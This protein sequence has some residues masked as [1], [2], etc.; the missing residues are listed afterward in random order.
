[1]IKTGSA[2]VRGVR[3][4]AFNLAIAIRGIDLTGA[5]LGAVV[6]Q[7]WDNDPADPEIEPVVTLD[8]VGTYEG[9]PVSNLTVAIAK[10]A[11]E[12]I[13]A[14]SEVGDDLEWVWYLTVQTGGADTEYRLLEGKFVVGGAAGGPGSGGTLTATVLDQAVTVEIE[15][16]AALGPLV[17]AATEAA[18]NAQAS[19]DAVVAIAGDLLAFPSGHDADL[20]RIREPFLF[21]PGVDLS[22]FYYISQFDNNVPGA[23][24]RFYLAVSRDDDGEG[25]NATLVSLLSEAEP[26]SGN[27][28]FVTDPQGDSGVYLGGWVAA[29]SADV[30]NATNGTY[31]TAGLL[32]KPVLD[33]VGWKQAVRD[34]VATGAP[35]TA[36]VRS[37]GT[38]LFTGMTEYDFDNNS[39]DNGGTFRTVFTLPAPVLR[40]RAIFALSDADAVNVARAAIA[41]VATLA[42]VSSIPNGDWTPLTF[43]GAE[44][45]V[46]PAYPNNNRR[47]Y[48]ASDWVN[49]A[50]VERTDDATKLP[51]IAVAAYLPDEVNI[52]MLGNAPNDID[53]TVWATHPDRPWI[54]R[55]DADDCVTTPAS[56]TSTTNIS[57]TPIIGL[58]YELVSGEV[59]TIGAIGDSIT[60]CV[61]L[62][63]T[64]PGAS[65]AFETALDMQSPFLTVDCANIGWT[66]ASAEAIGYQ[67]IDYLAFCEAYGLTVPSVVF[68]PNATPNSFSTPILDSEVAQ[69]FVLM[70]DAMKQIKSAG[71]MP[72]GWTIIPTNPANKDYG[73]SDVKRHNYNQDDWRET[74]AGNG[75]TVA[76]MDE[77]M[78]GVPDGDGQMQIGVGL[79]S[80]NIHP[81][82]AGIQAMASVALPAVRSVAATIGF[83]L[84]TL[85]EAA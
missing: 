19:E 63:T 68:C 5:T 47:S 40:M 70:R 37:V 24:N 15:G 22:K 57:N 56:F 61:A 27:S 85:V 20:D 75:V 17:A 39:G 64:Y 60:E 67:W 46:I 9:A 23:G 4:H 36:P 3:T 84:G 62:G 33:T 42:G 82:D 54:S 7:N 51:L 72:I 16:A 21:G 38:M 8:S 83:N 66:G 30:L 32:R 18:A 26:R 14:A 55:Y 52:R 80:D 65:W 25:T 6:L 78:R 77:V 45:A 12:A 29:G 44:A 58:Q 79:T 2:P 1:M 13:P 73:S 59:L 43:G 50:S 71:S 11:M 35:L 31:E 69:Q 48:I 53:R 74:Y 41:P 34:A 76:D 81:N 28:E 10:S 49:V